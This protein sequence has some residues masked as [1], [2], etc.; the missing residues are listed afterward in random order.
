MFDAFDLQLLNLV[1]RDDSRTAES[2]AAHVPR[3]PSAIARRLR[4]LCQ[5]NY[6]PV[7]KYL[8]W[9]NAGVR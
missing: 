2:L 5:A 4:R 7:S 8:F 9:K 3:S 6:L 1:Q